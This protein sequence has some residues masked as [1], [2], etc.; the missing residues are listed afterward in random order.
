MDPVRDLSHTAAVN[1]KTKGLALLVA[2]IAAVHAPVAALTWQNLRD[3]PPAQVRGNKQLWR[4][5]SVLNT[6][7]SV[8]YWLVGRRRA[9]A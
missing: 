4:I 3:R 1:N 6:L 7:G 9:A 5:A 2:Y 8:A